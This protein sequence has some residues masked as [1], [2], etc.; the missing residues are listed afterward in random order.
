VNNP[1]QE[2]SDAEQVRQRVARR[3]A[4]LLAVYTG[5]L[6]STA[7]KEQDI[8]SLIARKHLEPVSPGESNYRLT[9]KGRRLVAGVVIGYH[10]I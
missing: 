4:I 10:M 8:H 6:L 9:D 1:G 7:G 2:P 3:L 5:E